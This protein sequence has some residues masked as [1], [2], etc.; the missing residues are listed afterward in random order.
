MDDGGERAQCGRL[1][2]LDELLGGGGGE[3]V[4]PAEQV[5]VLGLQYLGGESTSSRD[6]TVT[7]FIDRV[8][9]RSAVLL[10]SN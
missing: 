10:V 2:L 8:P 7:G 9:T 5:R 1:D 6:V 4:P 3:L